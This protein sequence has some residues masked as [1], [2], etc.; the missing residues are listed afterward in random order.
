MKMRFFW[1]RV[2]R[3]FYM[4]VSHG[5]AFVAGELLPEDGVGVYN[6]ILDELRASAANPD[7]LPKA[8]AVMDTPPGTPL[9][10]NPVGGT[11]ES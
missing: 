5:G 8:L 2:N 7:A 11:P 6:L 3:R 9:V 4:E 1:N 10:L